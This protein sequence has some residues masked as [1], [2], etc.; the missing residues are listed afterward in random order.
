MC[1]DQKGNQDTEILDFVLLMLPLPMRML[2]CFSPELALQVKWN[3]KLL[4]VYDL[5][6]VCVCVCA[7]A[8]V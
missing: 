1:G 4:D 8:R 2:T 6:T 7:R 3:L 5:A